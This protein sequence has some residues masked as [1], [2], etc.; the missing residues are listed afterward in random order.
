MKLY[1][2]YYFFP[3]LY[4]II[5]SWYAS[6]QSKATHFQIWEAVALFNGGYL[7]TANSKVVCCILQNYV[8]FILFSIVFSTY[9]YRHFCN[10]SV[11]FFTR[12]ENRSRWYTKE[13]IK[14]FGFST[15]NSIFI[16]L[17]H[18]ATGLISK[19]IVFSLDQMWIVGWYISLYSIW[20]FSLT[21]M[22][23][24]LAILKGSAFGISIV[25]SVQ[26][27]ITLLL[28]T[29][30]S[31]KE[32]SGSNLKRM[33]Y[34]PVSYLVGNWYRV[35]WRGKK[36]MGVDPCNLSMTTGYAIW[37][38]VCI[39]VVLFGMYVVHKVEIIKSNKEI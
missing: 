24:I 8:P 4:G 31:K 17:G 18:I 29:I 13:I 9:I 5:F 25:F 3:F 22:A 1:W 15:L 2:K 37:G 19:K 35:Y 7:N 23:N 14:L 30:D 16:L 38:S 39:A 20:C 27:I 34:N 21:L 6:F 10:C 36:I 12:C 11:Y 26:A 28:L 32:L 33:V